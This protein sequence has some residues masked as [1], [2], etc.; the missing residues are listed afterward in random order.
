M[1]RA[2]FLQLIIDAFKV[3]P[4]TAILGPRQCGKT[5]L[6][7]EYAKQQSIPAVNYFD[8]EDP[9]DRDR[10]IPNPKLALESLKGLIVIDEIHY[11]PE[12]FQLLRV[13]V[14]NHKDQQYLI[15][16][17]ASQDLINQSSETLAGRISFIEITPFNLTETQESAHLWIK[18]GFPRSYLAQNDE[19]SFF[20]RKNFIRT[21]LERDIRELGI[22]LPPENLRRFWMMLA[23]YHGN[24]FNASEIGR[25]LGLTNKTIR[26]YL[27]ILVGTFMIRELKPWFKNISKRQIKTPKIYFRDSGVLHALLGVNNQSDL[28]THPKLGA[29]WEGFALE[30][31]LRFHQVEPQDCYFW[32]MQ[33]K[34]ELDLFVNRNGM[35]VGF[36]F[37]YADAPRMTPSMQAAY[38]F[39]DLD[40]LVVIY[41]G[42]KSYPLAI[43]TSEEKHKMIYVCGL[44]EYI[45]NPPFYIKI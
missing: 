43:Q 27:D 18:G 5:T 22:R 2:E 7:K 21:F 45:L 10:L 20:W 34:A 19:Q 32:G 30:E 1:E 15:L 13:L 28:L 8:L 35:K 16:G 9:V 42:N 33:Q 3:V 6:A 39:L 4:I 38:S 29:S 40:A 23:H 17:S 14:D 31:I 11:A 37:K 41:P 36:E 12:I 26:H 44:E 24:Y 25:S